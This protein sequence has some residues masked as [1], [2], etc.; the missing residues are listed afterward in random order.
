[1]SDITLSS[2]IR[3]NLLSLQQTSSD[4]T[5]TQQQLATGKKVNSA[6]DNPT[7]FFTSQSLT[8]RANDLSALLDQI[9]QA[10]QTLNAANDGLTGL[11]SLLEQAL[12]TAQQAQQSTTGT[13]TY[14]P[15]VGTATVG[16][17]TTQAT[18]NAFSTTGLTAATQSTTST[19]DAD[20]TG[21]TTGQTL[22]FQV[23]TGTAVTATFGASDSGATFA[24]TAHLASF[25]QTQLGNTAT[26]TDSGTALSVTSNAV[27]TNVAAVTG[28]GASGAAFSA[29]TTSTAGSKLTLTDQGGQ[30][31]T[32]YYVASDTNASATANGTFS[33]LAQLVLAANGA[34]NTSGEITASSTGGGTTLT[35][36]ATAGNGIT[37]GGDVGAS[38]GFNTAAYN[39][40]YNASLAT[41][42]AGNQNLTVQIGSNTAHTLTF[43]TGTGQISTLAGL[44]SALSGFGDVTATVNGSG[45]LSLTP[46]SSGAVAVGGTAVATFGVATSTT[47][48]ATVVTPDS[49]RAT[50]QSN[51]NALLTQID[52]LAGDSSYNGV[53]LL[54]GD[55]LTVNFNETGTSGLTIGGANFSSS[56][57]GLSSISG[58][59]FQ[60]NTNISA[61]ESAINAAISTVRAQTETF[62]T[63]SSTIS[64]RQ[65]FETNLINTLQTGASN[66]VLA[67]Q[68]Q[69]SANLLTEQTQQQLEISALSIANEANQSVLKLFG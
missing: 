46:T 59:G 15:I 6:F 69:A 57:L 58:S 62:G 5:T 35:L 1:M 51:F 66:L 23:G 39:D 29:P 33:N 28:T 52:Q 65:T 43:G 61:T 7:S 31:S 67:D 3:Q 17:D 30:T 41:A 2:G 64:T 10:Q 60:D 25:L 12:S 44:N 21:L 11:T 53:N 9:G 45:K 54:N 8:N 32:L 68:N 13:L 40:N 47:P 4:L 48:V 38:L 55:N 27:G 19:T 37:V 49:T 20:L 24:T 36:A 14:T 42:I 56:G 16:G 26:V 18:S 22:V 63:N 34:S 50:L